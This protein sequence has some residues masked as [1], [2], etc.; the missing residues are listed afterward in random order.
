MH[1]PL[2]GWTEVSGESMDPA[3]DYDIAIIGQ[4]G[5]VRIPDTLEAP[6][7]LYVRLFK[8]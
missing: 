6:G 1:H 8:N 2:L 5:F 7:K 3:L 4:L